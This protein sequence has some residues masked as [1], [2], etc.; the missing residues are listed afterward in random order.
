[1]RQIL[2]SITQPSVSNY[3]TTDN[4]GRRN[5]VQSRPARPHG[6]SHRHFRPSQDENGIIAIQV[7]MLQSAVSRRRQHELIREFLDGA[8]VRTGLLEPVC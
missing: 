7:S 4:V 2:S 3:L 6:T 5:G 8:K 1:M